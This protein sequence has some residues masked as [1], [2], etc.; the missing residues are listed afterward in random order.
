MKFL[1][2]LLIF[3]VVLV[4]LIFLGI[5]FFISTGKTVD[6]AWTEE[7]L[8]S[9]LEKS[10]IK[11]EDIEDL[12]LENLATGNFST[13][14]TVEIEESF[15][16]EEMSALISMANKNKGPIKNVNFRLGEEDDVEVSFVLSE[17][18][19]DFLYEQNILHSYNPWA[20]SAADIDEYLDS[21]P[22]DATLTD[23]IVSYISNLVN[24]KPVYAQGELYRD[25]E[26][27]VQARI[28]S[29]YVGRAPLPQDVIEKVE[30]ETLRVVNAIIAPENGF[31]IDEFHVRDGKLYYRGTLPE[32]VEGQRL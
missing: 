2:K 27:R 5:N 1:I 28:D 11:I 14:G 29:L 26:N 3:F 23:A 12:N 9:G 10:Q 17:N 25:S 22:E 32:E 20:V 18:F 16:S 8:L 31:R 24:S 7:D 30:Y 15:T 4:A 21:Q 19:V 13:Q 6:V